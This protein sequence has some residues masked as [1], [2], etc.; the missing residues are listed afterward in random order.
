M[1]KAWLVFVFLVFFVSIASAQIILLEEPK[2]EY[3][4][5]Q[6]IKN[7]V[8]ILAVS[9]INSILKTSLVCGSKV[10]FSE[11]KF[12][13]LFSGEEEQVITSIPL[14]RKYS[15]K[16]SQECY[17]KIELGE[18][19]ILSNSFLLK[20]DLEIVFDREDLIGASF[21]PEEVISISGEVLKSNQEKVSGVV[22]FYVEFNKEKVSVRDVTTNNLFDLTIPL[23]KNAPAGYYKGNLTVLEKDYLGDV[24]NFASIDFPFYV[25]Q[26]EK[27]LEIILKESEF[28]PGEEVSFRILLYDQTGSN[29]PA[30]VSFSILDSNGKEIFSGLANTDEEIFYNIA[31]NNLPEDLLIKVS[32]EALSSSKKVIVLENKQISTNIVN[33]TLVI[34][35]VGNV[36]FEDSVLVKISDVEKQIFVSLGIGEQEVYSLSAPNGVY[37]IEV[38][39][40]KITG[41]MLTGKAIDVKKVSNSVSNFIANPFVWF[42][43]LIIICGFVYVMYI[44]INK[45][46]IFGRIYKKSSFEE[47]T[48]FKE[49]KPV[50]KSFFSPRYI[51]K[52]SVSIKGEQ[53]DST[54]VFLKI[55]NM[56][57]CLKNKDSN[58]IQTIKELSEFS[59][60]VKANTYE[61]EDS[62][63]FIFAPMITKTFQNEK[64]A[65]ELALKMQEKLDHHNKYFKQK[66]NYGI[67]IS[68][69]KIVARI[70][71]KNG[72]EFSTKDNF[73]ALGKKIS[74]ISSGEILVEENLK[75][76]LLNDA[77]F[78]KH[79]QGSLNYYSL[80]ELKNLSEG[81]E[82]VNEIFRKMQK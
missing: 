21:S 35:N 79:S 60:K 54:G 36:F 17:I 27:N 61:S 70:L 68:K 57:D 31:E 19:S 37:D 77:V 9:D 51:A 48:D 16:N 81:R 12:I 11:E 7:P 20:G 4:F 29:I 50:K 62:V 28:N 10:G 25:K 2:S 73:V 65:L 43:I 6:I 56:S 23:P 1:K 46:K 47:Y 26:I 24:S 33:S 71:D 66:I 13:S 80:V 82:K 59:D 75:N 55:N 40:D 67:G 32:K 44:R 38:N 30:K 63:S 34:K 14:L 15:S 69:G 41:V 52:H 45:K 18:E 53:Q 78:E 72:L 64:T 58:A 8:K 74:G 22:S 39:E 5:G 42:F 49:V 76:K 3:Y